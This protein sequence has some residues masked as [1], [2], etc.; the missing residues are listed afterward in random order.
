M[1]IRALSPDDY[2]PLISAVDAWWGGRP[3][4]AM[5]PRLFFVHFRDTG[6]VAEEDGQRVGFVAGFLSPA[7]PDEAYI[8]FLVVHPDHRKRGVARAL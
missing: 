8:H 7:L 2:A 4:A 6:F 5:L 3:M 1:R